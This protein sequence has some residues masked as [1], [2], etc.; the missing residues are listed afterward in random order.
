MEFKIVLPKG[1]N[2]YELFFNSKEVPSYQ[3][4]IELVFNGLTNEDARYYINSRRVEADEFLEKLVSL[5]TNQEKSEKTAAE[6]QFEEAIERLVTPNLKEMDKAIDSFDSHLNGLLS[7]FDGLMNDI[8]KL[9][10]S[11]GSIWEK[12]EYIT[13]GIDENLSPEEMYKE[14]VK[15]AEQYQ[16][17]DKMDQ[18]TARMQLEKQFGLSTLAYKRPNESIVQVSTSEMKD[19]IANNASWLTNQSRET[20][21]Y[22]EGREITIDEFFQALRH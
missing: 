16:T 15:R 20:I 21:F 17:L 10:K 4:L 22:N 1:T 13:S 14:M 12:V 2:A 19:F 8:D 3:F 18:K 7:A 11:F 9:S 5:T 6:K